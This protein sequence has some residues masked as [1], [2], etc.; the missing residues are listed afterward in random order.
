MQ[1][2][3]TFHS[4][5]LVFGWRYV[6]GRVAWYSIRSWHSPL[7]WSQKWI[8]VAQ[9]EH[10]LKL[11]PL[12]TICPYDYSS[13][14]AKKSAYSVQ[15]CSFT[16]W[17][18]NKHTAPQ[19][20]LQFS[21]FS[22]CSRLKTLNNQFR[23]ANAEIPKNSAFR[24]FRNSINSSVRYGSVFEIPIPNRIAEFRRPLVESRNALFDATILDE[25]FAHILKSIWAHVVSV[26]RYLIHNAFLHSES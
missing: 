3:K 26:L 8:N 5:Y 9:W 24:L 18:S 12:T 25:E 23:K 2:R 6:R 14:Y 4:V 13:M 1:I 20:V 10:N 17:I 22:P 11:S 7:P 21:S 19:L 15:C 16:L